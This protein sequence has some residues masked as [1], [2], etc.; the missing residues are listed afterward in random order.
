MTRDVGFW[1][2]IV[3]TAHGRGQL[4]FI[5]QPVIALILGA[6]L[7]VAD[8]KAGKEPF[9]LRL[10]TGKHHRMELAKEALTDV[11]IP[12]GI[13]V[14]L[15]GVLQYLAL[16]RVRPMAA[17]VVGAT[18]IFVPFVLARSLTNRIVRRHV[19]AWNRGGSSAKPTGLHR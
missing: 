17:V 11:L 1:Q 16:G 19:R 12:F 9:F 14:V 18:L 10:L 5:I 7:A 15:D 3:D 6:R 4:R 8:A 13:A 2:G